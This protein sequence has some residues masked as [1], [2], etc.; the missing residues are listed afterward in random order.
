MV[1]IKEKRVIVTSVNPDE[2]DKFRLD[3][4]K[5]KILLEELRKQNKNFG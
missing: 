3:I 4:F 5:D 1:I 2:S